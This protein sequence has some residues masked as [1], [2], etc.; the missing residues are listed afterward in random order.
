MPA[1]SR[2]T[3]SSL[4]LWAHQKQAV[5]TA[6]R[7]VSAFRGHSTSGSCLIHMP[8]GTGK[9]G[10]IA[11]LARCVT[12]IGCVVVVAPRVALRDQLYREISSS[13]FK[14]LRRR[15]SVIPKSTFALGRRTPIVRD[16]VYVTTIQQ[17]QDMRRRGDPRY[18]QLIRETDLLLFDEG[19]YEPALVWRDT[20]RAFSSPRIIFTATP[21]RN[22]LKVFD[23][24]FNHTYSYTFKRALADHYVREVKFVTT[25]PSA[26]PIEFVG[27]V[28]DFYDKHL[29]MTRGRGRP[30]ARAIIRCESAGHI[31]QICAALRAMGRSCVGVHESFT[32]QRDG[33]FEHRAVPDPATTDAIFWVHQFKLLEGIDDPR[34]QLVAL[35]DELVSV[36]TLVQQVGRIVRNPEREARAVGYVLD[37]SSN[38]QLDLWTNYLSYDALI[39]SEGVKV[40]W[41]SHVALLEALRGA[42]QSVLYLDGRFRSQ[43]DISS[44]APFDDLLLPLSVSVYRKE[45]DFDIARVRE[46]LV[47]QYQDEDRIVREV[48][49]DEQVFLVL[50]VSFQ[51]SS[52]L[53][54]SAFI[55]PRLGVTIV[56]DP[57]EFVFVF[58]SQGGGP[59]RTIPGI[60]PPVDPET[61]QKLFQRSGRWKLASVA[62]QNSSLVT[63]AIRTRSVSAREIEGTVPLLD[64]HAFVCTTAYGRAPRPDALAGSAKLR[65][66]VGFGNGRVSDLSS[67]RVSLSAYLEWVSQIES[68]LTG[69]SE[70]I[71]TFRRW[72]S[73]CAAPAQAK[74]RN[75]LIDSTELEDVFESSGGN[76]VPTGEPLAFEDE[77]MDVVNGSAGLVANGRA[78]SVTV[79]YDGSRERY[80]LDSPDLDV[81]Y[82][83]TDE[84]ERRT[85]V[86]MLNDAQMFHVIPESRGTFFSRGS[87]YRPLIEF[88]PEYDDNRSHI[89]G[90]LVGVSQLRTAASEK[91]TRCRPG[92]VGWQAGSVFDLIDRPPAGSA[93]ADQFGQR[94]LLVCD[95]MNDEAADF[96][97]VRAGSAAQRRGIIFIHAKA[98]A[99]A[100]GYSASDLQDVCGQAVKNLGELSQFGEAR[101][102]RVQKWGQLWRSGQ[103]R[104]QTRRVRIGPSADAAW[105]A[106]RDVIRDPNADR[107][108]WVVLGQILSLSQLRA[109][110]TRRSPRPAAIQAAYLLFSTSTAVA[111]GGARLR[112][113]CSP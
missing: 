102:V 112:V 94:E 71:P 66:Y 101:A 81:M 90:S 5:E 89:L 33:S 48:V 9:T 106:V 38:R 14:R 40:L 53:R 103:V 42:E 79:T 36:R 11:T 72:A 84:D 21:Y 113:M 69:S 65:R 17:L 80:Q 57:A 18:G 107:E 6:M 109:Q 99:V 8:T 59:A 67:R 96:I 100:S 39:D 54:I 22:D 73:L 111:S 26:S 32:E 108:V 1:L 13:F 58:D 56:R 77:C 12:G 45:R 88:G 24:D 83:S 86:K 50:Y 28:V 34:F 93:L 74:P 55:E 23:V 92:G 70:P 7:Y 68:I 37:Q 29:A 25:K 87:F 10:V 64:D 97:C 51:N 60:G 43:A 98:R 105:R 104:G 46:A 19:H 3:I 63:T 35:Y 27:N 30:A 75:I 110:L 62:L 4:S 78:C 2:S 41:R 61:L 20:V 85:V 47:K 95:D 82:H 15:P 91:G 76:G 49:L 31:R 16:A 52:L 44:L